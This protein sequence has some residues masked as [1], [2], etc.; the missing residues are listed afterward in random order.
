MGQI[1]SE[2]LRELLH[3]AKVFFHTSDIEIIIKIVHLYTLLFK[4]SN[5]F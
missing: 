2:D 4:S 3:R 5:T 1:I